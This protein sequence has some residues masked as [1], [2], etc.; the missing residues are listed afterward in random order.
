M[1]G[2]VEVEPPSRDDP[3]RRGVHHRR[4]LSRNRE[5]HARRALEF[6]DAPA[7]HRG[8]PPRGAPRPRRAGPPPVTD[9]AVAKIREQVES[10]YRSD[11]RRV[12][13]TLIRLL[14]D[15]ELAEEAMHDA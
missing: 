15:F 8:P 1:L 13:A 10:V 6:A 4:S 2:L 7:R 3:E 14:G 9:D 5:T 12:L 11:S